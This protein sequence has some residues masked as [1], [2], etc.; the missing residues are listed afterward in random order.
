MR[1][2]FVLDTSVLVYDS[3]SYLSFNGN[4][5]V[6]SITTLDELDRVK[7]FANE[8]GKNARAAIRNLDAISDLGEIHSGIKIDNDI[9]LK[10]DTSL[11]GSIGDPA[12]GD[13]KILACASKIKEQDQNIP[14]I[15][16]SKDIN[17]R[18][19]AKSFGLIAQDYEKDKI[20]ASDIYDGF[21]IINNE[22][23]GGELITKGFIPVKDYCLDDFLPNECVLFIDNHDKGIISGKRVGDEIRVIKD[24]FPWGLKLRNKEQLFAADLILDTKIPLVSIIGIAGS[25]KT[26]ITMACALDLVINKKLYDRIIIY[27]PLV[28]VGAE[29]GFLPGSA[30][31]KLSPWFGQIDDA[32]SFL[33]SD[34]SAKQDNWKNKLF[35][36]IDNGTIQK[37]AISFIRGRSLNN[38]LIIVEEAQNLTKEEMRTILSRVGVE[39]KI[40]ISGDISQIDHAYLDA[41]NN[42]L[43]IAIEYFKPYNIAGHITLIKGERSELATLAAEMI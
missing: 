19:R 31:E 20:I 36:Y 10:I 37:E 25:G 34:K 41:T 24:Q 11:Y 13:N 32:F 28:S 1:K 43:S 33:C 39:S 9:V 21:R 18:T 23:A 42:G 2:I 35:Q 4:D 8:S 16:V 26:L 5:V 3:E 6:I 40:I 22:D 17:L 30:E 7:K 12:Y 15:L 29:I 27:R 14:V 38:S